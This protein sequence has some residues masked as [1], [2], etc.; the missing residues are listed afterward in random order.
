MSLIKEVNT[1]VI[2]NKLQ[3][4]DRKLY[5]SMCMAKELYNNMKIINKE[6]RPDHFNKDGKSNYLNF[7]K[8]NDAVEVE[9]RMY[10]LMRKVVIPIASKTKALISTIGYNNCSLSKACGLA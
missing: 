3:I 4:K 7:L 6:W 1:E 10:E 9:I 5:I 8:E 2:L